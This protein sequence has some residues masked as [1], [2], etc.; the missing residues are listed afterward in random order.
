VVGPATNREVAAVGPTFG[1]AGI[2]FISASA[3]GSDLT[4]GA[5]PTFFRVV[6]P[7]DLQGPQSARF[8]VSRLLARTVTV[9]SDPAGWSRQFAASTIPVFRTA[10]VLPDQITTGANTT[11]GSVASHISTATDVVVLAWQQPNAAQQLGRILAQQ[12]KSATIVGSNRL[13]APEAFRI[14]GSYVSALGPDIAALPADASIVDDVQKALPVFGPTG[15]PAYAATHVLDEAIA[16]VCQ[17]GRTP[18]R[19]DVLTALRAT[20]DPTSI[21]GIP[22]RFRPDGNLAAPRWFIFRID[23]AG[24]YRM[25]P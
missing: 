17:A 20:N 14:P 22:I 9:V 11:L 13:Y 15:P 19:S 12:R 5:N 1:R 18:S 3:T 7:D 25:V 24:R 16:S 2:A 21:L 8:I 4:A 23:S 6:A 10:R